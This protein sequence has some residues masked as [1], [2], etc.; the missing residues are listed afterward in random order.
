MKIPILHKDYWSSYVQRFFL[1]PSR[2]YRQRMGITSQRHRDISTAVTLHHDHNNTQYIEWIDYDD[3]M[4]MNLRPAITGLCRYCLSEDIRI[5]DREG[6]Y[7]CADCG[8]I[9]D[10]PSDYPVER[11]TPNFNPAPTSRIQKRTNHFKYWL[12]RIQGVERCRISPEEIFTIHKELKKQGYDYGDTIIN[13]QIIRATLKSLKMQHYYN[14]VYYIVKKFRGTALVE[15][16]RHHE[17]CL[18]RMF[19]D[20]QEPFSRHVRKGRVNM[21]SYLYLI[22]KF[23]EILGWTSISSNLPL[24]R[25]EIRIHEQDRVW[26]LICDDTGYPFYPTLF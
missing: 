16:T 9:H 10:R 5:V 23:C 13:F 19:Y 11:Y 21:L 25:S 20:I 4:C 12:H 17:E 22:R 14:H 15:F 18:C 1:L 26:R 2:V 6:V 8:T 24:L 7:V 3:A